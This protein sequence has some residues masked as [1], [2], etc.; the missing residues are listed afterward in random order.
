M[1]IFIGVETERERGGSKRD[2]DKE[3]LGGQSEVCE[4]SHASAVN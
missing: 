2:D 3:W 1:D 4:V